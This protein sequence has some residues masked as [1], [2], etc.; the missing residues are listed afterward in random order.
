MYVIPMKILNIHTN[1]SRKSQDTLKLDAV[2]L[3]KCLET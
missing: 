2:A 1:I 3:Y